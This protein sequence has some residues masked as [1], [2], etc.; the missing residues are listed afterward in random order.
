M[1]DNHF[2]ILIFEQAA[3]VSY[4]NLSDIMISLQKFLPTLMLHK[5]YEKSK[6]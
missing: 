4:N 1:V 3:N 5:A 2:I 6:N